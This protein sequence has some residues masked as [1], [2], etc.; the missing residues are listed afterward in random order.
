MPDHKVA[1]R[2]L[3]GGESRHDVKAGIVAP[4]SPW[5]EAMSDRLPGHMRT[6]I[7]ALTNATAQTCAG[8]IGA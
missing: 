6:E 2:E 4:L 3:Q 5:A 7:D 8:R 1:V